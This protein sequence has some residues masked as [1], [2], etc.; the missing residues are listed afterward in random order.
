MKTKFDKFYSSSKTE[1]IINE[2][3]IENVFQSIYTIIIA[4]IQNALGNGS[5]WIISSFVDHTISISKSNPLA[6]SSYIKLPKELD[7]PRRDLI[8]IQNTCFKGCL[9]RYL[10]PAD[11]NPRRIAKADKGF[12]KRLD[13]KDIKFPVKARDIHKIEKKII[14]A[15]AI[16]VMKTK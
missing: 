10:D 13:F 6:G 12:A 8:N 7:H 9:F 16:L 15:L 1:I 4:N 3:D 11:D 2:S 5:G 14:L